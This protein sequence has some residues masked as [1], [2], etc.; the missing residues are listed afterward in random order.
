[1]SNSDLEM[2]CLESGLD[3]S[4]IFRSLNVNRDSAQ[5]LIFARR[6]I[7]PYLQEASLKDI[8]MMITI[9]K[10]GLTIGEI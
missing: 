6:I 1:M 8:A 7:H 4:G 5:L 10:P 2:P 3:L 9:P